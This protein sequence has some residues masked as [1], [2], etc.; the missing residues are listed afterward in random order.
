M[1]GSL[2]TACCASLIALSGCHSGVGAKTPDASGAAAERGPINPKPVSDEEFAQAAYRVLINDDDSQERVDLLAGV[3]RRQLERARERFAYG[4]TDAGVAAFDGALYLIRAGE[5][6]PAMVASAAD[7]LNYA[8][9]EAARTGNEG[10]ARALYGQLK[11]LVDAERRAEIESHL[12]AIASFSRAT[13]SAGAMQAL[14]AVQRASVARALIEPTA[15]ALEAARKATLAWMMG[16]MNS[17]LGSEAPQTNFE[18][19][20][21]IEAFRAIRSGGAALIALYLRHGDAAGALRALD[22]GDV[23]RVVPP[24]LRTRLERAADSGDSQ[25]WLDLFRVFDS[26]TEVDRPETSLDGELAAAA[27]WGA[28]VELFRASP[29]DFEAT[30]PLAL[31]LVRYG[32]AEVMPSVLAGSMSP[33]L[34]PAAVGWALSLVLQAMVSE[35]EVAQSGAARRTFAAAKPLLELSRQRHLRDRVRPEPARLTYVMG[36]LEMH[37]GE[38]ERARPYLLEATEASPSV[39]SYRALAAVERQRGDVEATLAALRGAR[40]AAADQGVAIDEAEAYASTFEV[41]RDAGRPDAARTALESALRKALAAQRNARSD[42]EQARGERVLARVLE[43][44]G[45]SAGARRATERAYEASRGSLI[46]L[47]ITVLDAS[48]RAL[49]RSDVVTARDA[50]RRA[51]EANLGAEDLVYPA[52]WLKLLERQLQQPGDGTAEEALSMVEEATGWPAKLRAWARSRL[53]DEELLAAA[54]DRVQY[55]EAVFYLA[56]A[57]YAD[58]QREA[59]LPR[60]REVAKSQAVE[61][62]EV[63]IARD[64]LALQT[65]PSS[66]VELPANV[67][68]P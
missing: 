1:R 39:A 15:E 57:D 3:V 17:N 35:E 66:F 7:T 42:E 16:A 49:T 19:E 68:V 2:V 34:S 8:V 24:G 23:L 46:Q 61:L 32:M 36:A 18:R 55:T 62:V 44:Y 25:A 31:L 56:M 41:L 30:M 67:S 51:I 20:E 26:A 63:T 52:L 12:Q 45:D 37:A 38:L 59:A 27:A 53:S 21:A 43:H 13:K 11:P 29:N 54:R 48:R 5:F 4:H 58:G 65:V 10:R 22:E 64:L 9:D 50:V 60:L 33:E 40:Q 14:G 6:Y 28:A 47:S